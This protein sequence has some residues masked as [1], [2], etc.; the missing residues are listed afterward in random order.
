MR[1]MAKSKVELEE[2]REK[3]NSLM[4]DARAALKHGLFHHAVELALST[5]DHIDGMM[6]YERKYE[7]RE[8]ASIS[9]IDLVLKYAPLLFEF[10]NLD[11]LESLLKTRKRIER[12]TSADMAARLEK[13]RVQ[14]WDAYRLWEQLEQH[15]ETRQDELRRELG[16]K[17]D[18]WRSIVECWE[19]VGVVSR[20]PEGGSYRIRLRTPLAEQIQGKCTECGF[21]W[22]MPK[23]DLL[24]KTNCQS[25]NKSV[26]FVLLYEEAEA[27]LSGNNP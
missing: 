5:W 17:Q 15:S 6:Q 9:A 2:D 23:R 14:M 22:R 8:F 16:G 19:Q 10:E 25:C 13:A 1:I 20:S 18:T 27:N 24:M 7:D 11:R 26:H 21:L 4:S 12:D 3:Y